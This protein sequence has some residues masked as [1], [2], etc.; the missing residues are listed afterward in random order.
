MTSLLFDMGQ[1][2]AQT[3]SAQAEQHTR[4]QAAP[5]SCNFLET[6]GRG[7]AIK[8]TK[9]ES[10]WLGFIGLHSFRHK[11]SKG[12]PGRSCSLVPPLCSQGHSVWVFA[13]LISTSEA[14]VGNVG[15]R[16]NLG[17]GL[18]RVGEAMREKQQG[19]SRGSPWLS[20]F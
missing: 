14:K 5:S 17:T 13:H 18:L 12:S 2:Q 6:E 3:R 8:L 19:D 20:L 11:G 7:N 16:Q 1:L 9:G 15:P 4:T 10:D